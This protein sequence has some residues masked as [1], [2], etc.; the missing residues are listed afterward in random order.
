MGYIRNGPRAAIYAIVTILFITCVLSY[1]GCA[2][3]RAYRRYYKSQMMPHSL[4]GSCVFLQIMDDVGGKM[5][6]FWLVASVYR[7]ISARLYAYIFFP[8]TGVMFQV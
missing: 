4:E 5:G 2:E 1:V 8:I 6:N 3:K 7:I